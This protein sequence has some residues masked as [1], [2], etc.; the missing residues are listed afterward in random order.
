VLMPLSFATLLGGLITLIG[1][2]PNLLISDFRADASGERFGMFDFAPVGLAVA[3]AGIA[4]LALIGWRLIP[5][6][7]QGRA[8]DALF[9]ISNYVSELRV[10]EKSPAIGQS[11]IELEQAIEDNIRVLAIIRDHGRA[12]AGVRLERLR[13]GD[14]LIVQAET[15]A[16]EQAIKNAGL[17]LVPDPVDIADV[18]RGELHRA[19]GEGEVLL[20]RVVRHRDLR[21]RRA[22]A[23]EPDAEGVGA[24]RRAADLVGAVGSR[25]RAERGAFDTDGGVGEPDPRAVGDGTP[26]RSGLRRKGRSPCH[27]HCQSEDHPHDAAH[28]R[29]SGA[30][31]VEDGCCRPSPPRY[32]TV[33][34]AS[35]LER[36]PKA[37]PNPHEPV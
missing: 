7:R 11:V 20:H 31:C 30:F 2:P 17:E 24:A 27:C 3:G 37:G 19:A 25:R 14:I 6:D 12:A 28:Q 16:L 18:D 34:A 33:P 22:V 4:F 9:E 8:D 13:A 10:G 15:S 26:Y 29:A 35:S 32:R 36:C 1:T 23:D 5:K 21:D